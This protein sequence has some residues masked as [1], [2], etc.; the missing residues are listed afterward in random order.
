[1]SG[2]RRS[3]RAT[4][5]TINVKLN[6]KNEIE[7]FK[8][9]DENEDDTDSE[10]IG[11][12]N[13]DIDE[14]EDMPS[15]ASEEEEE[16]EEEEGEEE[17]ELIVNPDGTMTI[18]MPEKKPKQ[19]K[20]P[21]HH[22]CAKCSKVLSSSAALKRHLNLC[23]NLPK[24][25]VCVSLGDVEF[26]FSNI[27]VSD[28]IYEAICFCCNEEKETAH[29]GHVSCNFCPK[30]FKS[31]LSL[32]RHL[33]LLHSPEKQHACMHCN[34]T[35]PNKEILDAH[36]LSHGTGKPFSCSFCGKDFTRKYHLDR[37]LLYTSCDKSRKK[38]ETACHVCGKLFSRTDNLREH[39]R[40]HIGQSTRKRDYQC[41]H[42]EKSFYGSSLL[43]IHI[44]THTGEKPFCCD[45]C[46]KSFPSNGALRKHRRSHTGEKP[47]TCQTCGKSFSAK[48]TLNRHNK[49]HTGERP[50][51][52]THC[53]K[54]FIQAT[55][56]RS[57]MFH[58]TGENGFTCEQ[59]GSKFNRKN[60]LIT[61][62]LT[63]HANAASNK[64]SK[65]YKCSF[66]EKAYSSKTS[67]T[68]HVKT[69]QVEEP[70]KCKL[71]NK[72]FKQESAFKRHMDTKHPLM[73]KI[74][75]EEATIEI[76]KEDPTKPNTYKI[77]CTGTDDK[78]VDNNYEIQTNNAGD[79]ILEIYE[80][81][82]DECDEKP[83]RTALIPLTDDD[84]KENIARLLKTVVDEDVLTKFGYPK[85]PIEKVL[86]LVINHCGQSPV[87]S[88]T[89]P[90]VG[91]KLREN[92]KLLFTSVI[93]DES[94]KE[95]LNN[96]SIDEVI[97]HVIKLSETN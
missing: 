95:M 25:A 52:C 26:D 5:S 78:M 88:S 56:L 93:D 75:E 18:K 2:L 46:D 37:H 81:Q 92:V 84:L 74:E 86:S 71:C 39:L 34:A 35:C 54:S 51:A 23:K 55:Q 80:F 48:E 1:M 42:C 53:D 82:D 17:E 49:T 83:V 32:E 13:D 57:H 3:T 47:Y 41:P 9:E 12:D 66:C 89:C 40:A 14:D 21:L 7:Y 68:A 8:V 70:N 6:D 44:R 97:C 87:D 67:L 90:D 77:I 33:Y 58:H 72:E 10:H 50:Y 63:I 31:H 64:K 79:T 16:E 30:S 20:V 36:L 59:C 69:H 27:D 29:Y 94:I 91:S 61:H 76:I 4:T 45:L 62:M 96:H 15:E 65:D 73:E 19:K 60:R 24:N 38:Q 22:I 11:V 43:N 85:T 28:P